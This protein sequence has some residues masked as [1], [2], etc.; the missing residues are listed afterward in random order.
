MHPEPFTLANILILTQDLF[1]KYHT[2]AP[3]QGEG[4]LI[5]LFDHS[6]CVLF[7]ALLPKMAF[8]WCNKRLKQCNPTIV[9]LSLKFSID[10]FDET[11][12]ST[13]PRHEIYSQLIQSFLSVFPL[14]CQNK[15]HFGDQIACASIPNCLNVMSLLQTYRNSLMLRLFDV[16]IWAV[17]PLK[18]CCRSLWWCSCPGGQNK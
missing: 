12:C 7:T 2:C 14:A 18:V 8:F 15:A 1:C 4:W 5:G 16:T 3:K 10:C 13:V 9:S 11:A 17:F 6:S